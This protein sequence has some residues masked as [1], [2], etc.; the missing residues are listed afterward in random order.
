MNL[1]KIILPESPDK[2]PANSDTSIAAK[3]VNADI[4]WFSVM[5]EKKMPIE[6]SE[7]PTSKRPVRSAYR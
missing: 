7:A 2:L 6:I 5:D 3:V 4:I 1:V